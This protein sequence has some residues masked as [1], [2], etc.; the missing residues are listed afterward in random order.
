[1]AQMRRNG[2]VNGKAMIVVAGLIVAVALA[3]VPRSCC[4]RVAVW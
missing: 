1:M 4:R 2:R 3:V